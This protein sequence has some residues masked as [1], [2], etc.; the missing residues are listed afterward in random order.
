[1]PCFYADVITFEKSKSSFGFALGSCSAL[2]LK[3]SGR[4]KVM[5]IPS[6]A[7]QFT[8]YVVF[9]YLSTKKLQVEAFDRF[10]TGST[11]VLEP[12]YGAM[13]FVRQPAES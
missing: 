12:H 5:K 8:R 2:L 13:K 1:M 7:L 4:L 10:L 9:V 6:K 11:D 3:H